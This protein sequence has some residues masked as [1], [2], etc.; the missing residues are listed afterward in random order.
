VDVVLLKTFLE[1]ARLRHF[2]KAAEVL[3]VT[4]S[5]VSARIK[6]LE[7]TLEVDLFSRKRNDIQL[8]PA[9]HRLLRHAETMVRSWARARQDLALGG[10]FA[11]SLVVGL[12]ADLWRVCV[13]D[14]VLALRARRPDVAVSLEILPPDRLEQRLW[15]D[16]ADL[17][18]FFEPPRTPELVMEQVV[19]VPLVMVCDRPGLGVEEAM[20]RDYLLVDWGT[21]F[22]I[23]HARLFPDL[24]AAALRL[25]QGGMALDLLRRSGGSAYLPRQ[26]VDDALAAGALYLVADA[27]EIERQAYV[28]YRPDQVDVALVGEALRVARERAAG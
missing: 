6:L 25:S 26:M 28:V 22:T 23:S 15:A 11:R 27:P 14:W 9:G 20:A 8:T 10:D 2:G 16:Q 5:A 3:C 7:S 19:R 24:P 13:R 1:V 21:S 17:A 18:F 12:Q 4:Q